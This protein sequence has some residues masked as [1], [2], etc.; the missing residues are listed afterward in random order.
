MG[1]NNQV[2]KTTVLKFSLPTF[3]VAQTLAERLA[4][5]IL[6]GAVARVSRR[7]SRVRM[8][9]ASKETPSAHVIGRVLDNEQ[10]SIYL[11]I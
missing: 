1:H 11:M 6:P 10:P 9:E 4:P 7:L 5:S 3:G 8:T 2:Y